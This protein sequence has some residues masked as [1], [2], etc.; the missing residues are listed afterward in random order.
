MVLVFGLALSVP[1]VVMF[2]C[3]VCLISEIIKR[4][5]GDNKDGK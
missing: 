5:K 2:A 3:I 4:K 1:I